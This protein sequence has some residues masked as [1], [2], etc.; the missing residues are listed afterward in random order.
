MP[1][2]L[3]FKVKKDCKLPKKHLQ[4]INSCIT[5]RTIKLSRNLLLFTRDFH[6]C[7]ACIQKSRDLLF[8]NKKLNDI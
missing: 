8:F 3:V 4:Q 6:C 5:M 1:K 2:G 7:V